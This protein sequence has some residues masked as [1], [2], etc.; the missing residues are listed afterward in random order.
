MRSS[1]MLIFVWM[2]PVFENQREVKQLNV[3]G[4]VIQWKTKGDQIIF[5]VFAP[6]QGW[7]AVGFNDRNDI[8][9]TNL[10]IGASNEGV[11]IVEDQ[12]VS[13]VGVHKPVTLFGGTSAIGNVNC[14]EDRSGTTLQ[15]S[16]P[17]HKIDRLHYD[18]S[19]GTR[20]WLICAF[21]L[22]DDFNHHSIM[23]K[24]L[25]VRL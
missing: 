11:S 3:G 21:S 9:H 1:L 15:F 5:D 8:V 16:L 25:E 23:R 20:I 22:E 2:I 18:L 12:F 14:F 6:T 13:G 7:V 10:I 19:P 24:H 17:V 4:M